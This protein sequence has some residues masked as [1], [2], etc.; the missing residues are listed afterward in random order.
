MSAIKG[1]DSLTKTARERR[2]IL[3]SRLQIRQLYPRPDPNVI[4]IAR[5]LVTRHAGMDVK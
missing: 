3:I 2:K 1:S 4:C 5:Y